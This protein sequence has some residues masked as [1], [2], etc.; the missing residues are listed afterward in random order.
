MR[1][2]QPALPPMLSQPRPPCPCLGAE[3]CTRRCCGS[4][5]RIGRAPAPSPA[6][7]AVRVWD[8]GPDQKLRDL[9]GD[10]GPNLPIYHVLS[11][12]NGPELQRCRTAA[13]VV[14]GAAARPCGRRSRRSVVC[15]AASPAGLC[16][17]RPSR[18]AARSPAPSRIQKQGRQ[19][20]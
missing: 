6:C 15:C 7:G 1:A 2:G 19:K 18:A 17:T 3:I 4:P 9:R 12:S 20:Y 8:Q 5:P 11:N 13:L 16:C 14:R 10:A